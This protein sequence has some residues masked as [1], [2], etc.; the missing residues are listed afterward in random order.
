MAHK[1]INKFIRG[2]FQVN[3]KACSIKT[4][5][6]IFVTQ[7]YF[8][9]SLGTMTGVTT[10]LALY[11]ESAKSR[12]ITPWS[13]NKKNITC[14]IRCLL[15]LPTSTFLVLF[16]LTTGCLVGVFVI[17]GLSSTNIN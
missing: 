12:K 15:L 9:Q 2:I 10:F 11:F 13:F 3:L 7:D 5:E 17:T 1:P 14:E 4:S 8:A 6:K 16:S